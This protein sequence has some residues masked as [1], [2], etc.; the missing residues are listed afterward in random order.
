[1]DLML[2]DHSQ[3]IQ[4]LV[5]RLLALDRL[6]GSVP[7]HQQQDLHL[8]TI[9]SEDAKALGLKDIKSPNTTPLW[10]V[11]GLYKVVDTVPRF[12]RIPA[13]LLDIC[14]T[15]WRGRTYQNVYRHSDITGSR[16]PTCSKVLQLLPKLDRL[17][18][19]F[20]SN[21]INSVCS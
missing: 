10:D 8:D 2:P 17:L 12:D 19:T 21:K 9:F 13:T 5:L 16:D 3:D 4:E 11:G 1:M 20:L 7:L 6:L 14:K 18:E 15:S